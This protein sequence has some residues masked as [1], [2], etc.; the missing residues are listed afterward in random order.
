NPIS[1]LEPLRD[2]EKLEKSFFFGYC[3]NDHC[4]GS[5]QSNFVKRLATDYEDLNSL[6]KAMLFLD[7]TCE[8][9][10]KVHPVPYVF[11]NEA[12]N[13]KVSSSV[14]MQLESEFKN[15]I[16]FIKTKSM[17]LRLYDSEFA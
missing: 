15:K 14:P 9:L 10:D 4:L 12:I 1:D 17:K 3:E 8:N 2:G 5:I 16:F 13:L 7:V 6:N 11:I